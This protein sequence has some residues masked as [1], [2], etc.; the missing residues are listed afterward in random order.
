MTDT[1]ADDGGNAV[2]DTHTK[3]ENCTD[4]AERTHTQ[5]HT[6]EPRPAS[7][8]ECELNLL[9]HVESLHHQI[10][11]R[12]EVIERE[13]DGNAHADTLILIKRLTMTL[14]FSRTSVLLLTQL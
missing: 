2:T 4:A 3:E 1:T 9:E 14:T 13:L 11:A 5:T 7:V 12:M 8:A 6:P 10:S